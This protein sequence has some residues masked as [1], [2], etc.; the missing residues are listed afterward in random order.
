VDLGEP[1]EPDRGESIERSSLPEGYLELYK[2]AVEMADRVSAR[3]STAN[4]FFLT[5]QSALVALLGVD[6]IDQR[7]VAGAGLILA[8]AWW[9]L[10]RSYRHLNTAKFNVIREMEKDLPV[11]IFAAEWRSLKED[12]VKSWRQRYAEL[13]FVEQA[14]PIVFAVINVVVLAS[15]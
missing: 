11:Q 5:V 10:I 15:A 4:G 8:A 2:L 13:S 1:E 6:A 7:A 12:P 3:R 14:V 9:L